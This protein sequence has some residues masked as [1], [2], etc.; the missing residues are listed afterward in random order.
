VDLLLPNGHLRLLALRSSR[1]A[2]AINLLRLLLLYVG[3]LPR[4]APVFGCVV[5]L[6]QRELTGALAD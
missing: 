1:G 6:E 5:S 2:L 3:A 4:N